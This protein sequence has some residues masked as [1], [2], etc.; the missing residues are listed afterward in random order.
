VISQLEG[1]TSASIG[2]QRAIRT[3]ACKL[4]GLLEGIDEGR[5]R[6]ADDPDDDDVSSGP[7]VGCLHLLPPDQ[8]D[9]E[10][11]DRSSSGA[12]KRHQFFTSYGLPATVTRAEFVDALEADPSKLTAHVVEVKLWAHTRDALDQKFAAD[13]EE[14]RKMLADLALTDSAEGLSELAKH[15]EARHEPLFEFQRRFDYPDGR[16]IPQLGRS[17]T[18]MLLDKIVFVTTWPQSRATHRPV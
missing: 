10:D 3:A 1:Y 13:R 11:W 8:A 17:Q 18:G 4:E 14:L 5:I 15:I 7:L 6:Q 16:D 12:T 9:P 2:L